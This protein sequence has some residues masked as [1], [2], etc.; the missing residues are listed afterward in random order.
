MGTNPL[1][2]ANFILFKGKNLYYIKE[3]DIK[4]SFLMK[5]ISPSIYEAFEIISYIDRFMPFEKRDYKI[6]A[7]IIS[8][9]K[10]LEKRSISNIFYLTL[11]IE[12][13][14]FKPD[15]SHCSICKRPLNDKFFYIDIENGISI[16]KTCL[17]QEKRGIIEIDRDIGEFL[18]SPKRENILNRMQRDKL[19]SIVISYLEHLN[20]KI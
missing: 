9:L 2:Y 11:L 14:G 16:C 18:K 12:F 10:D 8:L 5:H 7:L 15:V 17:N 20:V 3:I 6:Y 4:R 13:L 19:Y 1:T